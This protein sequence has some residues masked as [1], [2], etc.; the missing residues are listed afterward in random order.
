MGS[1]HSVISKAKFQHQEIGLCS[2][3]PRNG[4]RTATTPRIGRYL[5]NPPL[6]KL[7]HTAHELNNVRCAAILV[8][9]FTQTIRSGFHRAVL[10]D[11]EPTQCV[12]KSPANS[13]IRLNFALGHHG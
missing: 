2:E 12:P 6:R 3:R 7:F 1:S 5:T 10:H 11:R 13:E 8:P 4:R 9:I